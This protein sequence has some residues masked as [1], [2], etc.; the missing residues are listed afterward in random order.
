MTM[1][2]RILM[3]LVCTALCGAGAACKSGD[4]DDDTA[5]MGGAGTGSGGSTGG[6]AG[7]SST[8]SGGG[9]AKPSGGVDACGST[10][11]ANLMC[12]TIAPIDG[13][14]APKGMCCQRA[15]NKDKE[16]ALGPDDNLVL[17]YRVEFS[18]TLNHPKTI[19]VDALKTLTTQRYEQEQQSILWRLELP[20]KGGKLVAG[21]GKFTNGVGRY[22]CDGTYSYYSDSAAP[23]VASFSSDKTRWAAVTVDV[24]FDPAKTGIDQIHIAFADNKNRNFTYTPFLNPDS[25]ALDW[26]LI[27]QGYDLKTIDLTDA[28]RDCIGARD[29]SKW[30]M[31]GTYWVYTPLKGNDVE[32]IAALSGQNYCQLAAFGAFLK[33]YGCDTPRCA[34]YAPAPKMN[35]TP[36]QTAAACNWQKLPDSLCPVDDDEKALFGCHLGDPSNLNMEMTYYP[37]AAEINCTPDKP[38]TPQDPS[39]GPAGQCCDPLG[40]STT[41]PACNA[42]RLVQSYVAA[43]AAITT[44]P[45]SQIQQKCM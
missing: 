1:R 5:S 30:S 25:Y 40:K 9:G 19:G 42:Y 4:D 8:G 27:N 20:R 43:A 22:N 7:S 29:G 18:D 35:P 10:A 21:K 37:P 36:E 6:G 16:A 39:T 33:T 2:K 34:P 24:D 3:A 45:T 15:S 23:D 11:A 14:C 13:D 17:E 28:G 32:P 44:E 26:E 31:G 41:L 12:P 38:T